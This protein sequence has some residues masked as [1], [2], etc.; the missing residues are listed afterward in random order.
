MA[1]AENQHNSD[2]TL[3]GLC[4]EEVS[5]RKDLALR[6]GQKIVLHLGKC[7]T[8]RSAPCSDGPE[9]SSPFADSSSIEHASTKLKNAFVPLPPPP[10]SVIKPSFSL[11]STMDKQSAQMCNNTDMDDEWNDFQS[12]VL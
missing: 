1:L 8:F 4:A 11:G 3:T 10:G 12:S 5:G 9:I 7:S 2:K 6:C